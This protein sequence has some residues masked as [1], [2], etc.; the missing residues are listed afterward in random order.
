MSGL[1]HTPPRAELGMSQLPLL[2]RVGR[3]TKFLHFHPNWGCQLSAK[4]LEQHSTWEEWK[5]R[6]QKPLGLGEEEC[7]AL[8][9][10][11][12]VSA[13]PGK[14]FFRLKGTWLWWRKDEWEGVEVSGNLDPSKDLQP[15]WKGQG[16]GSQRS[17]NENTE[18][19]GKEDRDIWGQWTK[20]RG[21]Q[22]Q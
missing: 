5:T 10:V 9:A 8:G 4:G 22:E 3:T 16:K 21:D 20:G 19:E 14:L 18:E 17:G 12:E 13:Q 11:G 15:P 1:C 6:K 7:L 2:W